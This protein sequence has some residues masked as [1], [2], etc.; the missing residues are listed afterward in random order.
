MPHHARC[1]AEDEGDQ[2]ECSM[3]EE[4][5]EEIEML[6]ES[7]ATLMPAQA[8]ATLIPAQAQATLMPAQAQLGLQS[9]RAFAAPQMI[10]ASVAPSVMRGSELRA[11]ACGMVPQDE[12]EEA[13]PQEA[14][15]Y[16]HVIHHDAQAARPVTPAEGVR[17]RKQAEADKRADELNSFLRA[18]PD[19]LPAGKKSMAERSEGGDRS[20]AP[21]AD[22]HLRAAR[23]QAI[24]QAEQG[25]LRRQSSLRKELMAMRGAEELSIASSRGTT[26]WRAHDANGGE[27]T[28]PWSV[29][30]QGGQAQAVGIDD[31]VLFGP[32]H[33]PAKA[34]RTRC[35]RELGEHFEPLYTY[36]KAAYEEGVPP[37][38]MQQQVE[39]IVGKVNVA[40]AILVE[41]LFFIEL[42]HRQ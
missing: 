26:E 16:T 12:V 17:L 28:R 32:G 5:E 38:D 11:S 40:K 7:Q 15:L 8:Q 13:T 1:A 24:D 25:E 19:V 14:R 21:A 42:M 23:R 6:E 33:S 30:I 4:I 36:M 20:S 10:A 35:E 37:R 31:P 34:M 27:E 3:D 29:G 39:Q 41:Q 9:A 2:L 22:G 18:P